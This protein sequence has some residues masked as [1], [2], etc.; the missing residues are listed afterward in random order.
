MRTIAGRGDLLECTPR[1]G[2]LARQCPR[3][4]ENGL[5]HPVSV[6]PNT[7]AVD[8]DRKLA[9]RVQ[10]DECVR[11]TGGA[12]AVSD[13]KFCTPFSCSPRPKACSRSRRAAPR[14]RPRDLIQRGDSSD[15]SV[16]V[17]I[18]GTAAA[19]A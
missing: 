6:R 2:W 9:R 17:C 1:S 19:T 3:V 14:S 13:E 4:F 5:D 11:E 18:T 15:E 10:A 7:T 12:G 8:C 16:V